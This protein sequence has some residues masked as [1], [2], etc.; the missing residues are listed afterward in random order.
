MQ[1]EDN[2]N[3]LLAIVLS[4]GVMVGWNYFYGAPKIDQQRQAAQQTQA[5]QTPAAQAPGS[6]VLPPGTPA[7]T[8]A[9]GA[10]VSAL[11]TREAALAKSPRVRIETPS[12]TGSV[13]LVGARIDDLSLVRYRETVD[14]KSP[15]IVLYVPDGAKDAYFADF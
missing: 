8:P 4:V 6:T 9:A 2:R 3:L 15:N 11:V 12:L 13:A 1:S 10:S 7:A 14:P 5:A